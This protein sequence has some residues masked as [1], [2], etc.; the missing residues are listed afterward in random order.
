M[1]LKVDQKVNAY[2]SYCIENGQKRIKIKMMTEN[3][4]GAC[5]CSMRKELNLRHSMQ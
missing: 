1:L 4:A 5:V 3:I 2:K